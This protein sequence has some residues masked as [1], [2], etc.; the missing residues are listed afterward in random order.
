M[1]R[2]A[3]FTLLLGLL[4]ITL[5]AGSTVV[6]LP[7]ASAAADSVWRDVTELQISPSGAR[8]I[9]PLA[10]RT[11]ALDMNALRAQL[12]TAPWELTEQ[13]RSVAVIVELPE[14][15]GTM[16]RFRVEEYRMMEPGLAAQYPHWH[17]YHG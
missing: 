17:T 16:G 10:Y 15:D 14:P 12:A 9:V 4:V 3:Q 11:V 8:H 5:I 2:A 1:K 13:S 7:P 6:A